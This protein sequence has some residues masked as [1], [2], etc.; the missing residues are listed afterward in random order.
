MGTDL[1]SRVAAQSGPSKAPVISL[2]QQIQSM[3]GEFQL[4]MPR[5]LEA[6]QL[7]R[8]AVTCLSRTPKLAQCDST[9]VLGGLM[10]CA[11]LGLRPAVLG[12]A[13]LLPLWN[14]RAR[15]FQAQLIIGYQGYTELAYRSSRIAS[16]DAEI[17]YENDKYDVEKGLKPRL[18]HK[19]M[20]FGDR[21]E[22]IAYYAVAQMNPRGSKFHI[23]AKADVEKHRDRFA[24]AKK[25]GVVIGP[26]KDHFDA[27]A[28]KTQVLQLAKLLPK[29]PELMTGIAVD[30][31]VR[32]DLTPKTDPIEVTE[33]VEG[34]IVE[35]IDDPWAAA[36]AAAKDL[37]HEAGYESGE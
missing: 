29:S 11:Q 5:G 12:Q 34:E 37:A 32:L 10:T 31:G 36:E 6:V 22:P 13:W 33:T 28:L 18:K 15:S 4:A 17:I 3:T 30:G 9:S 16:I 24:M 14:S 23:M 21:G 27:M 7:V 8:D 26:W 20:L 1:A 19:P 2:R 35:D 25:D